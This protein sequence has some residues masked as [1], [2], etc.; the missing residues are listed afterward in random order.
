MSG[1]PSPWSDRHR[2]GLAKLEAAWT[3]GLRRGGLKHPGRRVKMRASRP[4]FPAGASI[5]GIYIG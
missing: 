3:D 5:S 4:G 1:S 2:L